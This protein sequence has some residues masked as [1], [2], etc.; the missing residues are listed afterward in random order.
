MLPMIN[1]VPVFNKIND[2]YD[3]NDYV[4]CEVLELSPESQKIILTMKGEFPRLDSILT[5]FGLIT[6]DNFPEV[7]K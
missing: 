6:T 7:Y 2:R 1:T 4:C 5:P 3:V